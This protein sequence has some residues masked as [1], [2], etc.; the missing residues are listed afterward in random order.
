VKPINQRL[1]I[2]FARL[3]QNRVERSFLNALRTQRSLWR[4][5]SSFGSAADEVESEVRPRKIGKSRRAT[6]RP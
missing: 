4:G 3:D 6:D 2:S 1:P 5:S